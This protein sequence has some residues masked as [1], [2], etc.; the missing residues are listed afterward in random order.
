MS[1]LGGCVR[2]ALDRR[3]WG[4]IGILAVLGMAACDDAP[5]PNS[6]DTALGDG[7]MDAEHD[8]DASGPTGSAQDAGCAAPECAAVFAT[9]PVPIRDPESDIFFATFIAY[10]EGFV[11]AWSGAARD[12]YRAVVLAADGAQGEVRT[13]WPGQWTPDE[14]GMANQVDVLAI[15]HQVADENRRQTCRIGFAR[16]PA[17][18]SI[19]DPAQFSDPTEAGSVLNEAASCRVVA[20][21]NGFLAVWWQI[22]SGTFD[23][24]R[25]FAQGFTTEGD[26]RGDRLTLHATGFLDRP[27]HLTTTAWNSQAVVSFAT[28]EGSFLAVIDGDDVRLHRTEDDLR[29]TGSGHGSLIGH[30]P[31][32]VVLAD[33]SGQ[34]V[35]GPVEMD[36]HLAALGNGFVLT[37]HEEFLVAQ[38]LHGDLT[39]SSEPTRLSSDRRVYF[40]G[41]V[42]APD[43]ERAGA[44]FS[45]EGGLRFSV[46][47]CSDEPSPDPGPLACPEVASVTP[48]DPGCPD[49]VC[50]VV[51]RLDYL[52]LGLRGY[53]VRGG[54][55][56]LVT[57][58]DARDAAA[59][60][61]AEQ[62]YLYGDI[63]VDPARAGVYQATVDPGDFGAFALIGAESG[64]MITAGGVIWS[65]RGTY[66][67]PEVWMPEEDITCGPTPVTPEDTFASAIDC[68]SELGEVAHVEPAAALDVALRTN[69]AAFLSQRGPFSAYTYLYTPTVGLCDPGVAEYVVV[70]SQAL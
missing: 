29:V 68:A 2:R 23:E 45:G 22:V 12:G 51:L 38:A 24:G 4:W 20:V 63:S 40:R 56:A 10:E 14:R 37:S 28:R 7:G 11:G 69:V 19:E 30:T 44:L 25:I 34:V 70:L 49:G 31:Q 33:E 55:P 48:L 18:E 13:L 21:R 17:F 52:N 3:G 27:R 57:A 15:A 53:T 54:P 16:L 32:G 66:W 59:E 36:G 67:V 1:S 61:F 42:P 60:A 43:G 58:E 26:I 5:L 47:T 9:N 65:G 50:H 35:H 64:T 8:G 46:L 62:P 39:V 41:L 6:E